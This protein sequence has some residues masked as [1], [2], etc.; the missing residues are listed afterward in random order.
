MKKLLA[1]FSILLIVG[2]LTLPVF[3]AQ[4]AHMSVSASK[5]TLHRGDTFTV[6]VS[7]SAV[8][9]CT[10]GSFQF[11]YDTSVFDYLIGSV[12]IS[13]F[14]SSGISASGG[15]ASG[16]FSGG[17]ATV[18]GTIFEIVLQVK[19]DAP[20]GSYT[21]SGAPSMTALAD[22]VSEAVSCSAG[23]VTVNVAC[24]HAWSNWTGTE[25]TCGV[26]GNLTRTCAKC[27]T[28]ETNTPPATGM[29]IYNSWT[30]VDEAQHKGICT[31][32][33]TE[34]I[35]SHNWE[36]SSV[37]KQATCTE[38]GSGTYVCTD[39]GAEKTD[40]IPLANHSYDHNCDPDCNVCG[41]TR[42]TA[43]Q[44]N[45]TWTS[46]RTGHWLECAA[47]KDRKDVAEH[48]AGP[49]ATATTPQTCTICGYIIKA[50]YGHRHNY[51]TKWTTDEKGHWHAC[52]GCNEK[53]N[54]ADHDFEN[55]CDTNCSICDYIREI[56]H[57]LDENWTFDENGHWRECDNCGLKQ[58]E[59]AHD[60]DA[61]CPICGYETAVV[62]ESTAPSTEP[63]SASPS[64]IDQPEAITF[65]WWIVLVFMAVGAAGVVLVIHTSTKKS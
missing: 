49:D 32:C 37:T 9:N 65:P 10:A 53:G 2:M 45:T 20:I 51:A 18:Q 60:P 19:D 5:T 27:N 7:A 57:A 38:E 59:A 1:Y 13:G 24:D 44:Y 15:G 6:T 39:C 8:E 42:E 31:V 16:Y 63:E 50:A 41:A 36:I 33:A 40:I 62:E 61:N 29:H 47:C 35:T 48:T 12:S 30:M 21:I 28:T 17:S 14:S 23:G 56:Q 34:E 64:V 22:G 11:S 54:Y 43:H 52:S 55:D 58:D 4:S 25:A 46:D 26:A 3:A